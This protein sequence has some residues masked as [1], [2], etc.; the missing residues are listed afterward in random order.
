MV[1]LSL[2]MLCCDIPPWEELF[3]GLT[4]QVFGRIF[5]TLSPAEPSHPAQIPGAPGR[6]DW[7]SGVGFKCLRTL[8][9][10]TQNTQSGKKRAG[11]GPGGVSSAPV[12]QILP[13][14]PNRGMAIP[15]HFHHFTTLTTAG[16][17][18]SF[19]APRADDIPQ[20]S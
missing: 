5:A 10:V 8:V 7:G 11:L 15:G 14:P 13:R 4:Q 12:T 6:R 18:F 16:N 19:H 17:T 1:Y 9:S 2:K 20:L 3:G